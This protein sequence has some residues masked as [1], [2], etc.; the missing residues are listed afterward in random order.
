M[1]SPTHSVKFFKNIVKKK[2]LQLL[3][4]FYSRGSQEL[5]SQ[6]KALITVIMPT[7]NRKKLILGAIQSI[8][9]QSYSNW[10]LIIIDDGSI[11]YTELNVNSVFNKYFQLGKI[12]YIKIEKSGVSR[13]RNVGLE[14]AKGDWVAYLD[15]DNSW[16]PNYLSTMLS[17]LSRK[18][19]KCGYCAVKVQNYN[20]GIFKILFQDTF[21]WNKLLENNYID[22]NS[23]MHHASLYKEHG[24]FD[25]NLT[26]LVDW[27]L[28]LRYTKKDPP[29]PVKA[30]LVNY[31]VKRKN[32]TY[33]ITTHESFETNF[34]IIQEKWLS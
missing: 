2:V 18:E 17:Q 29:L 23:F 22:L 6:N 25:K 5:F 3:S 27:D 31:V 14:N 30:L 33:S 13:A 21:N 11:D 19:K 1:C 4:F 15:S 10:E 7:Y 28:I 34:K 9:N 8:V 20:E 32:D 12:K 24:G 16:N 26:R